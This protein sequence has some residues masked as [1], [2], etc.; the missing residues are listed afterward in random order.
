MTPYRQYVIVAWVDKSTLDNSIAG[1][2]P[3]E[4]NGLK[5]SCSVSISEFPVCVFYDQSSAKSIVMAKLRSYQS[6]DLRDGYLTKIFLC[7][8]DVTGAYFDTYYDRHLGDLV[9]AGLA[10][11]LEQLWTPGTNTNIDSSILT[12]SE[13][14]LQ[15]A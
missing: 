4:M 11:Q 6:S 10:E 1:N 9:M 13:A 2:T 14:A 15:I 5:F 7:L 3:T 8:P 12:A